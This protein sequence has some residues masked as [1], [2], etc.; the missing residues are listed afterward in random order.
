M[1]PV[2]HS[3]ITWLLRGKYLDRVVDLK[4]VVKFIQ[5]S[6]SQHLR[7]MLSD[8]HICLILSDVFYNL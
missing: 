3:E 4:E 7:S 6:C 1:L 2:L 5:T 8:F